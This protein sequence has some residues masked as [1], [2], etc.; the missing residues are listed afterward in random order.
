LVYFHVLL[1]NDGL[2]TEKFVWNQMKNDKDEYEKLITKRELSVRVYFKYCPIVLL[3][4]IGKQKKI[5]VKG[6][7][8]GPGFKLAFL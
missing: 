3:G 6:A 4:N 5:S 8:N 1:L 7:G 2:L